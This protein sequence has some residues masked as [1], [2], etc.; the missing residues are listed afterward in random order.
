MFSVLLKPRAAKGEHEVCVSTSESVV[1]K[2]R[3]VVSFKPSYQA[4]TLAMQILI[5]RAGLLMHRI[6]GLLFLLCYED[7]VSVLLRRTD[8][9]QT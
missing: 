6:Q 9:R 8:S 4:M 3:L 1:Y 2:S 7:C 5:A